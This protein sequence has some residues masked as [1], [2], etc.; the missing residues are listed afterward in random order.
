MAWLTRIIWHWSI[1][2]GFDLLVGSEVDPLMDLERNCLFWP[3]WA[4]ARLLE[5]GVNSITSK[6]CLAGK[7]TLDKWQSSNV[8]TNGSLNRSPFAHAIPECQAKRIAAC[9]RSWAFW[10]FTRDHQ[11]LSA[12]PYG[13]SRMQSQKDRRILSACAFRNVKTRGS[14][15]SFS[16]RSSFLKRQDKRIVAVPQC[17]RNDLLESQDEPIAAVLQCWRDDLSGTSRQ[18]DL[19]RSS[20]LEQ[21][22][23]QFHQC[24]RNDPSGS[25]PKWSS[26]SFMVY[27]WASIARLTFIFFE[28]Y[29]MGLLIF[30]GQIS[31]DEITLRSVPYVMSL[32]LNRSISM[33]K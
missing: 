28:S 29:G 18:T 19:C 21:W 4:Y 3:R 8:N 31:L 13:L 16:T 10:N 2:S 26:K 23:L 17:W 20:V 12:F 14:P 11:R 6:S 24:W 9:V 5:F 30:P 27:L 33:G 1:Q 22:T 32:E 7:N 15:K 25:K